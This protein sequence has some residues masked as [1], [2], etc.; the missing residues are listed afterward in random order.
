LQDKAPEPLGQDGLI[1]VQIIRAL[2]DSIETGSFV[3][4][5]TPDHWRRPTAEQAIE[6]PPVQKQSD[7]IHAADPAGKS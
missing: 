7:L 3:K 2:Y 4:L 6:R 1:D 5:D